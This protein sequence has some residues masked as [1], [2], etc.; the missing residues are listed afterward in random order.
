MKATVFT[1]RLVMAAT[2]PSLI[3]S[4]LGWVLNTQRFLSSI[5]STTAEVPTGASIGVCA[6]AM[7]CSTPMAL[8]E[9]EGP[10]S[11][12][13]LLSPSSFLVRVTLCVGSLASSYTMYSTS[14]P[15]I[16]FGSRATA[17]FCGMPTK[18]IAPVEDAMTPIL[19]WAC[20]G[21]VAA[22]AIPAVASRVVIFFIV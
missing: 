12:S 2:R 19:T 7:N 9:P 21:S 17:F 3:T 5:G 1:P 18:G 8:P 11:A 14:R 4:S 20:A 10:I 22:R 15:S 13:I 6:S 16:F